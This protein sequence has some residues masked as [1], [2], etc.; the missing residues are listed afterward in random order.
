VTTFQHIAEALEASPVM[1]AFR[2]MVESND[3][4]RLDNSAAKRHHFVSQFLLRGFART[5]KDKHCVFQMET[6]ARGAPL[7]VDVRTAA[8]RHRFYAVR[9]EDGTMSNR[10]EGYLALVE[11]H[12][13]PALQHLLDDPAT[14]SPGERATIA[15]FIALQTMRTPAAAEQI[16][17]VANAAF[18]TSASEFYS[19][20]RAFSEN[21]RDFFGEEASDEEIEQFRQETIAQIHDG[22]LRLSGRA[23]ALSAGLTHAV[24]NVPML[25][26]FDWTLLRASDGG[27]ITSDRGYAIHDPTP[28]YPWASQGI[29]SSAKSETTVPLSDT[30]CLVVRPLPP[31][32]G[33]TAREAAAREI[34]TINLRT[35]GWADKYVFGRT[36]GALVAV[37][38][39]ARR[40]PAKVVRPKPFTQVVLLEADPNDSSL[41]EENSRRGWPPQLLNGDGQ[42][43]DYIVIPTDHPHPELRKRADELA[44]RRARNRLGIGSNERL[45]G[46]IINTPLHLVGRAT[47]PALE[48]A[49]DEAQDELLFFGGPDHC[50]GFSRAPARA[51]A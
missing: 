36:Q 31:G 41:A 39:A 33:L 25:I 35:Y 9:G 27:F 48:L 24:D 8:S 15:F 43:R 12:A 7:R 46:H 29:L 16:T 44:E 11:E 22:R 42:L 20:R 37:R 17:A 19:D 2:K 38:T 5:H 6:K 32:G 34:E 4:S 40:D 21:Y 50:R 10:N 26:E 14:L 23:A 28:P 51:R 47:S 49:V 3:F 18:R 30:A 13:A 1:A 45:E